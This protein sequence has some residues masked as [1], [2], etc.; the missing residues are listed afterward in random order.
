MHK[1]V[2]FEKYY[3]IMLDLYA[4]LLAK[5]ELHEQHKSSS[6]CDSKAYKEKQLSFAQK[7]AD[8]I[9]NAVG[10]LGFIIFQSVLFGTWILLNS[11]SFFHHWDPYPFVLMNLIVSLE[12]TYAASFILISQ[13]RE[14][15]QHC[16]VNERTEKEVNAILDHLA[17]Q[18]KAISAIYEEMQEL[19]AEIRRAIQSANDKIIFQQGK[20]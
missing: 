9:A 10:S 17:S 6:I 5:L 13:N 1:S 2:R 19:R 14:H 12:A 7:T 8:W 16:E 11:V 20:S 3:K 4:M 18:D 15:R